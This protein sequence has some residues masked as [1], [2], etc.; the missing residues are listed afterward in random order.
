MFKLTRLATLLVIA[1]AFTGF[2]PLSP[3]RKSPLSSKAWT[4]QAG[5]PIRA[6]SPSTK[7]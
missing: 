2:T 5:P 7:T 3:T 6:Q 4:N 1:A